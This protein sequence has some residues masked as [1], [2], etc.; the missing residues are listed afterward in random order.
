[1]ND[2]FILLIKLYTQR[3]ASKQE[4]NQ[5]SKQARKQTGKYI[6]ENLNKYSGNNDF[7]ANT[8]LFLFQCASLILQVPFS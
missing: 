3:Q 5:A 4:S 8:K 2:A 7:S 1:M 6:C